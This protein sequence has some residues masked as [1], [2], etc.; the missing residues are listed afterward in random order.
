[1]ADR[2]SDLKITP[3]KE[4]EFR[5]LQRQLA[6]SAQ[7][8]RIIEITEF[9]VGA[10]NPGRITDTALS[11]AP[12]SLGSEEVQ[13]LMWAHVYIAE[14]LRELDEE[15]LSRTVNHVQNMPPA[16]V[17]NRVVAATG[18]SMKRAGQGMESWATDGD[19]ATC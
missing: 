16:S 15:R 12:N 11:K 9:L 7:V 19:C 4:E 1:M 14:K 18:R 2:G 13:G 3:E 6:A 8:D 5:F 10:E 17:I